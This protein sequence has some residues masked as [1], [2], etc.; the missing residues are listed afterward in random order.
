[1]Y[2]RSLGCLPVLVHMRYVQLRLKMEVKKVSELLTKRRP[3]GLHG[4]CYTYLLITC[5]NVFSNSYSIKFQ[6]VRSILSREVS[7][8]GKPLGR[9]PKVRRPCCAKLSLPVTSGEGIKGERERGGV[10]EGKLKEVG[11]TTWCQQYPCPIKLRSLT[12]NVRHENSIVSLL[13]ALLLCHQ[14][15]ISR[16]CLTIAKSSHIQREIVTCVIYIA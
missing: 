3:R 12:I 4:L 10:V 13:N 2:L 7:L 6:C 9:S 14:L 5:T 15:W 16:R 1:M 8:H 11:F